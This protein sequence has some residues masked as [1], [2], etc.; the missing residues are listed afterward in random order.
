MRSMSRRLALA[1]LTGLA[2][3]W[4]THAAAQPAYPS[5]P[6]T[7]V[8]PFPAGGSTDAVARLVGQK[9]SEAWGQSVVVDN[10]GGAAGLIGAQRV[11]GAAP[12][13]HTLLVT[14][15]ALIQSVLS[16]PGKPPYDPLKDFAPVTQINHAPTVFIVNNALPVKTLAEF[17]ALVK[18]QPGKHSYGSGGTGQTLHLIG[19]LLNRAAGMDMTHV[20]FKGDAAIL[21]DVMAGHVSSGFVTIATGRA[22]IEAGRVRALAVAGPKSALLPEVPSLR[23]LGYTQFDAV[24]WFG[25][26]APGGTPRPIVDKIAAEVARIVKLPD[27]AKRL[28]ELSLSPTGGGP[29]EFARI[30]QR[31]YDYWGGVMKDLGLR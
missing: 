17:V 31:D 6:I 25:M 9:L 22:H 12:D 1:S 30:M 7:I 5:Q 4:G 29:E 13:G 16:A 20:P 15:T 28:N 8:V 19:E 10:R 27:V 11:L 14:N 23:E 18:S 26:F 2:L 24:G 21:N 3:A